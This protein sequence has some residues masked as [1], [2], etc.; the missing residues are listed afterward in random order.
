MFRGFILIVA[1]ALTG[2]LLTSSATETNKALEP[3]PDYRV[4][5]WTAETGLPQST[6]KALAQTP[7]GYLWVGTLYG[8]AR[9][10]GIRFKVFDQNNTSEMSNDAI[11]SLAVDRQDGSLWVATGRGLVRYKDY[12]FER[13]AVPLLGNGGVGVLRAV[14]EGGVWLSPGDGKVGLFRGGVIQ[15]W[16]VSE[17]RSTDMRSIGDILELDAN[18][19]IV[20]SGRRLHKLDLAR[21]ECEEVQ[22][23]GS[24]ENPS[25]GCALDGEGGLWAYTLEGIWK[26]KG[27]RWTRVT[28]FQ[29][30]EWPFTAGVFPIANEETYITLTGTTGAGL[31]RIEGKH[32]EPFKPL[33]L[34]S[35]EVSQMIRDREGNLWIGSTDGLFRLEPKRVKVYA[36]GLASANVRG[37]TMAPDGTIWAATTR[38]V[39]AIR[40]GQIENI[41]ISSDRPAN[42]D[43]ISI[44][45]VDYQNRVWVPYY[46]SQ[47]RLIEKGEWQ[48]FYPIGEDR[49]YV[50][51]H[52]IRSIYEDRQKR[53]WIGTSQGVMYQTNGDWKTCLTNRTQPC[54][55]RVIYQDHRGDMW[56][57]TYGAGL[58]R[59]RD[60]EIT[61]Y[62]TT[63]GEYNNRAWCIHEDADGVFWVGSQNGLNRFVPPRH[64]GAGGSFFTFTTAQGLGENV[65]NNI[66]EDDFGSLWLSGLRGVY[67][68]ARRDLN[69]VAA[70][71][72]KEVQCITYGE[73]DGMLSSECNGGDNQP[74]GCKDKEG[75]IWFPTLKGAV[76]FDPKTIWKNEIPPPVVLEQVLVD[77]EIVFG[78][79]RANRTNNFRAG[80]NLVTS[81]G[82]FQIPGGHGSLVEIHYAGN[83]LTAP[84]RV[85]FRY[86]LEPHESEWRAD[87]Q[88]RRVA[89]YTTLRPGTYIFRV[90]ACNN[91]GYWNE[92]GASFAFSIAPRFSQTIWLPLSCALALLTA[93]G[94]LA[95]WRLRW[96]RQ[97]HLEQQHL[98][99]EQE[100]ARIARNLHDDLSASL[101]GMAL[102]L[103][104]ARQR[105]GAPREQLA[106]LAEEARS[107]ALNLR[108]TA[109][110]TNPRCDT[111]GS[112]GAFLS[113][114]V[115]RFCQAAGLECQL[116]V[117][118]AGRAEI[119]PASLRHELLMVVK[120]SL[121][122]IGKH[123]GARE[124]VFH[125]STQKDTLILSLGDDGKGFETTWPHRGNG[126]NNLQERI[127]SLG[128]R[129]EIVS[130]PGKGTRVLVEAALNAKPAGHT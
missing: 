7:D 81:D 56:F 84:E 25:F 43:S 110:T 31:F 36:D 6:V 35:M 48:V 70:G 107:L 118:A 62:T 106:T 111:A 102:E 80:R 47:F 117:S 85:R 9:F 34:A 69:E 28:V 96:Q 125:C 55:V 95:A 40:D 29:D 108:E 124:V 130:S 126:L 19:L 92:E 27:E 74:A 109:W 38:G 115:E 82:V 87:N 57:G 65:I 42:L 79:G 50:D 122:N 3:T 101:S 24:K 104:A 16:D 129:L 26:L 67:Q 114:T 105:G 51:D 49:S 46:Y 2:A 72:M 59:F 20:R 97:V 12:H 77:N 76:M 22:Y 44:L 13:C 32:L 112:L 120:E 23:P 14:R 89:S 63:R 1:T 78:D 75:R 94:G 39:S 83:C 100:R 93:S 8:L 53:I 4:N 66:Q 60:G 127:E 61:S 113:E 21:N 15:T 99:V 11:N 54:D 90:K 52:P 86:K 10:D 123:A 5:H 58:Y 41:P 71:R 37:L 128:G 91:H 103:E 68:I 33:E 98:A 45:T 116:D 73:A 30:G 119:V 17:P 64:G 88:N 18:H 121:N